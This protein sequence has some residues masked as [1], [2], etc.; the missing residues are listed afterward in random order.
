MAVLVLLHEGL[1]IKKIPIEKAELLIGRKTD[2]DIFLDDNMVSSLHAKIEMKAPADKKNVFDYYVEDL[3]STNQT[4]V[5]GQPVQRKKLEHNDKIR[6][7]RHLFK[8]IDESA[9]LTDKTAKLQKSWIPG[10]YYTKE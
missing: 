5:N 6:I 7:G 10:V 8:F 4:I 3:Q 9:A 2:C 1:T